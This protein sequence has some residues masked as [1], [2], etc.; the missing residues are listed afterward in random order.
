VRS[1][2]NSKIV[3]RRQMSQRIAKLRLIINIQQEVAM[4]QYPQFRLSAN[5]PELPKIP[6]KISKSEPYTFDQQ[7]FPLIFFWLSR[8]LTLIA[9]KKARQNFASRLNKVGV[10]YELHDNLFEQVNEFS[11]VNSDWQIRTPELLGVQALEKQL[12][13]TVDE[14]RCV[15]FSY[16]CSKSKLLEAM[17]D[18]VYR[19]FVFPEDFELLSKLVGV[20]AITL[21]ELLISDRRLGV[22]QITESPKRFQGQSFRMSKVVSDRIDACQSMD[23]DI[24]ADV[25]AFA[26]PAHIKL[27]QFSYLN[28]LLTL[29]KSCVEKTSTG[30]SAPLNILFIGRPG[31]GKTELVKALAKHAGAGLLEVPVIAPD[32]RRDTSTYRLT[33]FERISLM[34]N[35]APRYQLLFD[36]VEDVLR[37]G[38]LDETRKAWINRIL[39]QRHTTS[40]WICNSTR[41]FEA[42]FMRR[43][44]YVITMPEPDFDAR[45]RLLKNALPNDCVTPQLLRALAYSDSLTPADIARL[46]NSVARFAN[47]QLPAEKMLNLAFPEAPS[48]ESPELGAFDLKLT[49]ISAVLPKA[50]MKQLCAQG[51]DIKLSI[52]GISG[53]GKTALARYLCHQCNGST[54]FYD[55]STLIDSLPDIFDANLTG[56][57][58]RAAQANQLLAIDN[59]D[60]LLRAIKR[61]MPSPETTLHEL[62]ARIR[63]LTV[64]IVITVDCYA[65]YAEFPMLEAAIDYNI[66]MELWDA[67]IISEHVNLWAVANGFKA[68]TIGSH[69]SATPRQL[70]KALRACRFEDDTRNLS[71]RLSSNDERNQR[72]LTRVC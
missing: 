65:T 53:S 30:A 46:G 38:L 59:L 57:F 72:L 56:V 61:V 71:M 19:H 54:Q 68:P 28:E 17:L 11:R 7:W 2:Q 5:S 22:M 50:R 13:L 29:L 20:D 27:E 10:L 15:A 26:S 66:Q 34:I 51:A 69:C 43:F 14:S 21:E 31:T 60:H 70:I 62:A 44:D 12:N 9:D 42:S 25:L 3:L 36:E 6:A 63:D 58:K 33:E 35:G 41:D 18:T 45:I 47:E 37:Q 55:A 67:S 16:L 39:E 8:C 40:Y 1:L 32:N 24:L 48:V 4:T 23:D 52:T 64:P 49:P